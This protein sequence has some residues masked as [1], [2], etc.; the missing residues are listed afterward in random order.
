M[1]YLPPS[2]P[3]PAS[4]KDAYEGLHPATPRVIGSTRVLSN[5]RVRELVGA[6]Q[7]T[8]DAVDDAAQLSLNKALPRAT[9]DTGDEC[10]GYSAYDLTVAATTPVAAAA[11][12]ARSEVYPLVLLPLTGR[13]PRA[14]TDDVC[15]RF[16]F[17]QPVTAIGGPGAVTEARLAAFARLNGIPLPRQHPRIAGPDR[18]ATTAALSRREF[19]DGAGTVYLAGGSA[20]ADAAAAT[21]LTD[22]PVLLVPQCGLPRQVVAEIARLRPDRVIA[23]GSESLVCDRNLRQARDATTARPATPA[24]DVAGSSTRCI[25]TTAGRVSCWGWGV[26]SGRDRVLAPVDLPEV[27]GRFVSLTGGG[28]SSGRDVCAVTKVGTVE[29]LRSEPGSETQR[30]RPVPGV[31]DV[32]MVDVASGTGCAVTTAGHVWC[33]GNNSLGQLGTGETTRWGAEQPPAL[34]PGVTEAVDVAVGDRQVCA[35]NRSGGVV[36]WG[37]DEMPEDYPQ[38]VEIHSPERIAGLPADVAEISLRP[39]NV[40]VRTHNG[41]V[42]T[43]DGPLFA[44]SRP[45]SRP[46]A[47]DAVALV[48]EG[49]AL[50]AD[51]SQTCPDYD[52]NVVHR[53]A[54]GPG[55]VVAAT[56]GCV[57]L[58]TGGVA[59]RND[60]SGDGTGLRRDAW[61][62][63]LG[64][65]PATQP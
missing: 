52:G 23:L 32:A 46:W 27:A 10:T 39:R 14:A 26:V 4:V 58:D 17:T 62:T 8:R 22:G 63:P 12:A 7:F 15:N 18:F 42:V 19:P 20:D 24:A 53:P 61:V 38:R 45:E 13:L 64:F 1:L 60:P 47:R 55:R 40:I 29:C 25:L 44:D 43:L 21:G 50:H 31:S 51:G 59:C 48:A 65:R 35:L 28:G 6:A 49:C 2:G 11:A 34:V 41:E 9:P 16:T 5:A 3:I 57:V 36:C 30:F 56:A 33:W 54:A 37:G